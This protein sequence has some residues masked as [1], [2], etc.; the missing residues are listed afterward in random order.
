M[1]VELT[2]DQYK[3]CE[4]IK[5]PYC[6]DIQEEG[7]VECGTVYHFCELPNDQDYDITIVKGKLENCPFKKWERNAELVEALK[8][9]K[10]FKEVVWRLE[11]LLPHDALPFVP[12]EPKPTFV[13]TY[14]KNYVG[15][16]E[17]YLDQAG[18]VLDLLRQKIGENDHER[19]V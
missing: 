7:A 12:M 11:L 14:P 17:Q 18:Q 19:K 10:E 4:L 16:I 9:L 13:V 1:R 15:Y 5:C 8:L 2:D 3:T 6:D